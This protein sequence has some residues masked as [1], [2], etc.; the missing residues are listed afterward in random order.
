MGRSGFAFC[1]VVIRCCRSG[2][3][4]CVACDGRVRESKT[5]DSDARVRESKT[6]DSDG[7]VLCAESLCRDH[8]WSASCRARA[9]RLPHL[10]PCCCAHLSRMV[11]VFV[12][13]WMV[14]VF[15][16]PWMVTVFVHPC[17][18]CPRLHLPFWRS[19]CALRVCPFRR[20][21]SEPA[22]IASSKG[23]L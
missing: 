14:T 1:P 8:L 17:R 22:D 16:D 6:N 15:V 9:G 21:R 2:V 19:R 20:Q 13:P 7:R 11:T 12:H 4:V 23:W 3:R 18:S 5:N 10:F